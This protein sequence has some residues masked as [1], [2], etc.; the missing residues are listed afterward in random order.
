MYSLIS[1]Y[2]KM[3]EKER[4]ELKM[5]SNDNVISQEVIDKMEQDIKLANER[6]K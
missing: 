6:M 2:S 4:Q 3:S 1:E 5:N